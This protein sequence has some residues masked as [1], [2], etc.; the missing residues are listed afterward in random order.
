MN[1]YDFDNTIYNGES[2]FDFYLFCVRRYPSLIR[3]VFVIL[4]AWLRYRLLLLSRERLMALAEK[5]A[6]RFVAK[7]KNVEELVSFFWDK[8]QKK[9][10]EFYLNSKKDDDVVV[11]ASVGFLLHEICNRLGIKGCVCSEVNTSS[12]EILRLCY[13]QNKPG[14]FLNA[15]PEGSIENFY[16][17]SM[18]DLPMMKLAKN[19]YLVKGEK[20]IPVS[21]EKLM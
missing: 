21:R 19:A 5:Y 7:V 3:Y 17:D 1:V 9:I 8:N 18:N 14:Y 11:S 20:I 16:S 15:F 12:G 2:V 4:F 13:R 10:K 6:L